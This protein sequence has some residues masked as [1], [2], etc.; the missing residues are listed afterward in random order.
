MKYISTCNCMCKSLRNLAAR[1]AANI[2]TIEERITS[3]IHGLCGKNALD[4]VKLKAIHD[5]CIKQFPLEKLEMK[6][7]AEKDM[8]NVI[9]EACQKTKHHDNIENSSAL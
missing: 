1:L 2:F 9:D 6:I 7:V 4:G 8:R 3:N 5:L